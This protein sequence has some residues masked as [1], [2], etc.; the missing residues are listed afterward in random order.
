M[1]DRYY[2]APLTISR[3]ATVTMVVTARSRGKT[4][5]FTLAAIRDWFRDR[6]EFVYVRRYE[7]ELKI[8]APH[9]FDDIAAHDEFPGWRFRMSGNEGYIGR[10]DAEGKIKWHPICHCIA[11]SKQHNYK[12]IP[13]PKVKKIIFDE[14]IRIRKTPPGYLPDEMGK[15]LDLMRTV[16]RERTNVRAYL[17]ANACDLVNPYFAFYGI[18][19]EPEPGYHWVSKPDVLLHFERDKAFEERERGNLVGRLVDGTKYAGVMLANEFANAGDEFIA[20]KPKGAK[21]RY[22]FAFQGET[23]GVWFDASTGHYFV[24]R[25]IVPGGNVFALSAADMAPNIPVIQRATPFCKGV[26]RL[27]YFGSLMFDTPNTRERFMKMLEL[28]GI[29]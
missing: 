23:F 11:L 1:S 21:F 20:K 29:R 16:A 25:K 14:F 26:V 15:F 3:N 18:N 27:F 8:S 5:G 9:V 7:S 13:F 6:S 22:G 10:E 12:G 19:R 24:N 28:L 17:L 2:N 4:Y